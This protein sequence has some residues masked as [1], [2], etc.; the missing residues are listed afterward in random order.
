MILMRYK[1]F[2]L[3]FIILNFSALSAYS[4]DNQLNSTKDVFG[5]ELSHLILNGIILSKDELSSVALLGDDRN[6]ENIILS[7]GDTI[8]DFELVRI[9]E[10][11][12][13]FEA[14]N[15]T[16]QLFLGRSGV[17]KTEKNGLAIPYTEKVS[18]TKTKTLETKKDNVIK[19][20]YFRSYVVKRILDEW[21]MILKEIVFFPNIVDGKTKGFKLTKISEGSFLSEM[22]IKN[23]DI[24][25]KLNN[26]ELKDISY[27]ST[28]IDKYKNDDRVEMTID[29]SGEL[30]RYI[31]LLK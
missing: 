24:I 20:E 23:N 2:L 18:E 4:S 11:R 9:L 10:N 17:M 13:V 25:I 7:I 5:G 6:S 3:L 19:K 1:Y 30:I 28:L 22:G 8:H 21:E 26:E 27:L 29:R 31:Y 12:I 16:F 15:E 14:N